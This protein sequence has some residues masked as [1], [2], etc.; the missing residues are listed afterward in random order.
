VFLADD[1]GAGKTL[2]SIEAARQQWYDQGPVLPAPILVFCVKTAKLQWLASIISQHPGDPVWL[3]NK[4][5]KEV[6]Q[7]LRR[8]KVW[9]IAHF[10]VMH[11]SKLWQYITRQVFA[12]MIVDEAHRIKSHKAVWAIRIRNLKARRK[13]AATA[14]PQEK[15]AADMYN[16]L[17][18]LQPGKYPSYWGFVEQYCLTEDNYFSDNPNILGTDPDTFPELAAEIAPFYRR[19]MKTDVRSDMPEMIEESVPVAMTVPQAKFYNFLEKSDDLVVWDEEYLSDPLIVANKLALLIRLWQ[20]ATF[21]KSVPGSKVSQSGK[22]LWLD[23]W[24]KDNPDESVIIFTWFRD[25]AAHIA[26]KYSQLPPYMGG[27]SNPLPTENDQVIVGTIG[28]MG[29]SLDLPWIST[30]IFMN[31]SRSTIQMKQAK[32]RIYRM[33]ITE[34]KRAMY[35]ESRKPS[36]AETIDQ[37]IYKSLLAKHTDAEFVAA[38]IEHIQQ[39][40]T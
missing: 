15:S 21:P 7:K 25:T 38:A 37:V 23:D 34:A 13:I 35:L 33:T 26:R 2:S 31:R 20:S 17:R 16:I 36:G 11:D 1:T 19:R 3:V 27:H 4:G 32:D 5:D 10:H 29:E 22:L 40:V 24:L 14:T 18:F 6:F 12:A 30:A 8:K 39:S 28:S 9:I